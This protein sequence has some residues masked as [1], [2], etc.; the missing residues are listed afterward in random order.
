M[1]YAKFSD[2]LPTSFYNYFRE[3]AA[4][5]A[6][7][8]DV[9][10]DDVDFIPLVRGIRPPEP[11]VLIV[12]KWTKESTTAWKE[13][14]AEVKQ[15]VDRELLRSNLQIHVRVEIIDP[16]LLEPKVLGPV[17][18]IPRLEHDWPEIQKTVFNMLESSVPTRGGVNALSII[19][20]GHCED[21]KLNPVTVFISMNREISDTSWWGVLGRI[22]GYLDTFPYGL[23][24]HIENNSV[25]PCSFEL[26]KPKD[27]ESSSH[28]IWRGDYQTRVNLGD[29]IGP[30]LYLTT[31]DDGEKHNPGLGTMGFYVDIKTQSR[32]E[33]TTYGVTNYHVVRPCFDGFS[34]AKVKEKGR[35]KLEADA[36]IFGSDCH[37][38]DYNGVVPNRPFQRQNT[39]APPRQT[40]NMTISRLRMVLGRFRTPPPHARPQERAEH[41]Q[42]RD[43]LEL[44]LN[45]KLAFFDQD[46]HLLGPPWLSSGFNRKSPS[47]QRLDWA[48]IEVPE[49]RRGSNV[50]PDYY[51]TWIE[52]PLDEKLLPHRDACGIPL[53][54]PGGQSIHSM[55]EGDVVFKRGARTGCTSGTYQ[56]LKTS[57]VLRHDK[58]TRTTS[59]EYMFIPHP[60]LFGSTMPAIAD[61]GD[62]GAAVWNASGELLGLMFTGLSPQ[63]TE[64]RGYSFITPIEDVLA[65]IK[66]I[67]HGK[68]TDIRVSPH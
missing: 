4:K 61:R 5:V 40:H 1:I 42:K 36:P 21:W 49:G 34:L 38:A 8:H 6:K 13:I 15:Y 60:E 55:K 57:V 32:L 30:S 63:G 7:K 37:D 66:R 54:N 31:E 2:Y 10:Y 44:E 43:R 59:D 23:I 47:N 24:A 68:I 64:N 22:Q 19:R 51:S 28:E 39:E 9:D 26:L 17:L 67:S 50:L 56:R 16:Q 53:K 3:E 27:P 65:D 46:K 25:D 12:A 35:E 18:G 62:S 29:S 20:L 52:Q 45:Q 41:H 58:Y 33:W 11:T 48:L 14:V